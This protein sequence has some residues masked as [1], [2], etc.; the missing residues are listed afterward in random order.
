MKGAAVDPRS[1]DERPREDCEGCDPRLKL[2]WL[3]CVSTTSV[4]LDSVIAL[5]VLFAVACLGLSRVRMRARAWIALSA[6]FVMISWSTLLSQAMFYRL[7]PRTVLVTLVEEFSLGGFEFEGLRIYREGAA[8]GLAQSLRVLAV[9]AAGFS[10]CLSTSAGRLLAAMGKLRVPVAIGFV[11]VAALRF[12]PMLA[13]EWTTVRQARRLRGYR[14]R[15]GPSHLV[16]TIRGEL[17]AWYP[18]A[19]S[20]V[21]RSDTFA[22]A[23]ASRGFD[24]A[25]RRTYFPPLHL[26]GI[27]IAALCALLV[28]TSAILFAKVLYWCYVGEVYYRSELLALYDFARQYL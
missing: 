18:I 13:Q 15:W 1:Y 5:C 6:L 2:V 19:A 9:T 10:V 22:T 27:E 12:L 26:R 14:P 28:V 21:R 3:A 24:G 8:Y 4:L 11:T 23:I 20:A 25:A 17:S 16:A 7:E